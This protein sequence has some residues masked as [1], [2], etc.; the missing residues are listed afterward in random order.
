MLQSL[1]KKRTKKNK[2]N[3]N[4]NKNN[5]N[6]SVRPMVGSNVPLS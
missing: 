3:T 2:D 4:D 6:S 5:Q 1:V